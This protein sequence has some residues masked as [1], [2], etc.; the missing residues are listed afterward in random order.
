LLLQGIAIA[1]KSIIK[2]IDSKKLSTSEK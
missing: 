1:F 2:I